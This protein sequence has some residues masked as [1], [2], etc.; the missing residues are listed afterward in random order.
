[1]RPRRAARPSRWLWLY[2]AGVATVPTL[3]MATALVGRD[4]HR[5]GALIAMG[6][7]YAIGQTY[8]A[9]CLWRAYRASW[10]A[11]IDP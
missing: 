10:P 11:S 5:V 6:V 8:G 7:I 9:L 1:M 3:I 2:G 4:G